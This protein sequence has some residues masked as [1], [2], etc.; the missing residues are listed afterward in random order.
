MIDG[1]QASQE[2]NFQWV[3]VNFQAFTRVG[4]E[5]QSIITAQSMNEVNLC[6]EAENDHGWLSP[7]MIA[8]E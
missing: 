7:G 8:A 1:S 5:D 2:V 3:Q 6:F 4:L